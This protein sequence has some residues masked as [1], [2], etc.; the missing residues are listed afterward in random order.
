MTLTRSEIA[1]RLGCSERTLIR[2][3]PLAG[4]IPVETLAHGELRF[5]TSAVDKLRP[6]VRTTARSKPARVLSLKQIRQR[7]GKGGAR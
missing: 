4:V 1:S 2:K 7:A 5:S 6:F 3:E